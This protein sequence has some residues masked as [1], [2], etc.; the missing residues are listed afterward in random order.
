MTIH[1]LYFV[2]YAILLTI[3]AIFLAAVY[4]CEHKKNGAPINYTLIG[5]VSAAAM[6]MWTGTAATEFAYNPNMITGGFTLFF[7]IFWVAAGIGGAIL[8]HGKGHKTA[9]LA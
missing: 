2:I 5:A 6:A 8:A 7:L 1:S 3:I 4:I 9:K